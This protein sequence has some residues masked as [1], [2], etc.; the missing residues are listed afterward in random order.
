[1]VKKLF[2]YA[3]IK[4]GSLSPVPALK[5]ISAAH[6]RFSILLPTVTSIVPT[7]FCRLI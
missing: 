1:M 4:E 6:I 5:I 3:G 7:V 2:F